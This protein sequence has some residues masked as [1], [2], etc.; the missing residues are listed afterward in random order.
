MQ[1]LIQRKASSATLVGL[2]VAYAYTAGVSEFK[3]Y[4]LLSSYTTCI[5]W[6]F[7]ICYNTES[8]TSPPGLNCTLHV[9]MQSNLVKN[10]R[11]S[12]VSCI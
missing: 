11:L 10:D 12:L 7:C 5:R 2:G 6:S 9:Y 3:R 4:T 1:N 8:S